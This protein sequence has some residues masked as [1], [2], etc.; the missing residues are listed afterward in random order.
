MKIVQDCSC[1]IKEAIKELESK[2]LARKTRHNDSSQ[3]YG[4]QRGSREGV[5]YKNSKL[6][7]HDI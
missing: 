1:R 7:V 3:N 2:S 4:V 5:T 6:G